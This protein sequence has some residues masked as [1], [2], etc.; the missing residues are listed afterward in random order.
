MVSLFFI[1]KIFLNMYIL[2]RYNWFSTRFGNKWIP[3]TCEEKESIDPSL[4]QEGYYR[5]CVR[6]RFKG[7]QRCGKVYSKNRGR[8][9]PAWIGDC[10]HAEAG[11]ELTSKE[12]SFVIGLQSVFLWSVLIRKHGQKVRK[13]V[14]VAQVLTFW[15]NGCEVEVWLPGLLVA[16][17]WGQN[18]SVSVQPL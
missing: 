9:Q 1:L 17:I 6:H 11:A 10:W 8:F 3:L 5:P 15:A 2:L 4:L 18:L 13:L 16:E 12:A 7:R 14:V